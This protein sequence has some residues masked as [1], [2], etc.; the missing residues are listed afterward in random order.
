MDIGNVLIGCKMVCI[1]E[2]V[3]NK[4]KYVEP[5]NIYEVTKIFLNTRKLIINEITFKET[6]LVNFF[7]P[8][9]ELRNQQIDNILND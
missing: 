3:N 1:K 8:L 9:C 4:C 7:I 6:N 5:G 2:Y